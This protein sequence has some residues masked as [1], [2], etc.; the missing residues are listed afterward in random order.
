MIKVDISWL[1]ETG[2]QVE[3][4]SAFSVNTTDGVGS[5]EDKCSVSVAGYFAFPPDARDVLLRIDLDG[6]VRVYDLQ[7]ISYE[8]QRTNVIRPVTDTE[9][10]G[11]IHQETLRSINRHDITVA[12]ERVILAG[13]L[14]DVHPDDPYVR[15]LQTYL[16]Q[17]YPSAASY[18]ESQTRAAV[19]RQFDE[20]VSIME[21]LGLVIDTQDGES[22]RIFTMNSTSGKHVA[23]SDLSV[24]DGS[25][26][27][28]IPDYRFT[29]ATLDPDFGSV[30]CLVDYIPN[31]VNQSY[32]RPV[33]TRR[34]DE[35]SARPNVF[36]TGEVIQATELYATFDGAA[37]G[38]LTEYERQLK[39]C[40]TLS[41]DAVGT[42]DIAPR[43][44][45]DVGSAGIPALD[46]WQ[47]WIVR[48]VV[49]S[50]TYESNGHTM[51]VSC[52]PAWAAPNN[53]LS[54]NY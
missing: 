13:H 32:R 34:L 50:F 7:S 37:I 31:A 46:F 44:Y 30:D 33:L 4:L 51:T 45:L 24:E 36:R 52:S 29:P 28:V 35:A 17:S 41:F 27:V 10:T 21:K 42:Y 2:E 9:L 20:W 47:H 6:Q 48:E 26:G 16:T 5:G 43:D 14:P 53:Y 12:L 40:A 49:R 39:D 22:P 38:S 18:I 1:T 25:L 19:P 8:T 3:E 54:G 11:F 23:L 15:R